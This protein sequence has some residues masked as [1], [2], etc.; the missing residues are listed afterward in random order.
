MVVSVWSSAHHNWLLQTGLD[1]FLHSP[2]LQE[3]QM[4]ESYEQHKDGPH[5]L[6]GIANDLEFR[7]T[8]TQIKRHL[9]QLGLDAARK[10]RKQV[11]TAQVRRQMAKVHAVTSA[12]QWPW[13]RA[14]I[15]ATEQAVMPYM[16]YGP[17]HSAESNPYDMLN[18]GTM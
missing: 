12:E 16:H 2:L 8:R 5:L 17:V 14:Y 10:K 13:C 6:E 7:F 1:H 15:R 4:R 18:V 3:R 11:D 9:K